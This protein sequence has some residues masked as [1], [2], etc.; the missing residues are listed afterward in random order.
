WDGWNTDPYLSIGDPYYHDMAF[1]DLK[2]AVGKS[3]IVAATGELISKIE[4]TS[5]TIYHFRPKFPVREVVFSASKYFIIDSEMVNEVNVSTYYLP[6]V[7]AL[8]TN[9]ALDAC[10]KALK[11]FNDSFGSY[12]YTTLNVIFTYGWYG[13]MEYPC[14]VLIT[15]TESQNYLEHVIAHE[16]GH[17]WWY[18]LV[19]ND[20]IDWGFLDEGLT[21]WSTDY[22]S[23]HYHPEWNVFEEY[24]AFEYASTYYL[25]TG[26]PSKINQSIY[27]CYVTGTDYWYIAYDK[28]PAILEKLRQ[29]IGHEDFL[30]SVQLFF[31]RFQW[32]IA[33]L[34]D[35]QQAFEDTLGYDLDWYF[36]PWFDNSYLPTYAFEGAQYDKQQQILIITVID[37]NGGSHT[38]PYAQELPLLIYDDNGF[39]IENQTVWLNGSIT[40]LTFTLSQQP[41]VVE[42]LFTGNVLVQRSEGVTKIFR[43]INGAEFILGTDFGSLS[44]FA[45]SG[46]ILIFLKRKKIK[47][48]ETFKKNSAPQ[49]KY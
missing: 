20:E 26:N 10:K 37:N 27:E 48:N 1:Y 34:T 24:W 49:L 28:T 18:Q 14:Q 2:I 35:L 23:S 25:S 30:A 4:L 13:G 3:F 41:A 5:T 38:Y 9:N 22:Y 45:L 42:L 46:L 44:I 7:S 15:E 21:V 11:F 17:Q 39:V 31:E 19:G 43:S 40:T 12:P 29:R 36:L 32:K 6:F 16:V 8:W 47:R 33:L